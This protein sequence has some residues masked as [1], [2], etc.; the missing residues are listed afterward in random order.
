VEQIF[1]IKSID[2]PDVGLH[3]LGV[4]LINVRERFVQNLIAGDIMVV[5]GSAVNNNKCS[6]QYKDQRKNTRIHQGMFFPKW[7]LTV[8]IYLRMTN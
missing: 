5:E 1:G 8:A 7:N 2:T 3:G 6:F 4:N